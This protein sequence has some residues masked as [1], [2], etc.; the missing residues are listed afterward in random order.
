[1][2]HSDVTRGLVVILALSSAG[3][4]LAAAPVGAA[5]EPKMLATGDFTSPDAPGVH[6]MTFLAEFDV[7]ATIPAHSHGGTSQ[8][9][10]LE[11]SL[12][13]TQADGTR[14]TFKAGDKFDEAKD[15]V[16][17]AVVVGDAPARLIWTIVLPDGAEL[18]T[19]Q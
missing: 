4:F 16:H 7:G 11:G 15:A 1:M 3:T 14:T 12:E 6:V 5:D 18:E 19:M 17:S 9:L 8:V 13:V 2:F 10:M